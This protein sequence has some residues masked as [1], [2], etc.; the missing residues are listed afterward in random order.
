M[1]GMDSLGLGQVTSIERVKMY[2]VSCLFTVSIDINRRN[3]STMDGYTMYKYRCTP[4]SMVKVK[5]TFLE[6]FTKCLL[7]GLVL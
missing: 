4:L 6:M 1:N 2:N 3:T 5:R 7:S